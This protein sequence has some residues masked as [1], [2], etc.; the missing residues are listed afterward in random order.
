MR[1]AAQF[2]Q[3]IT[4]VNLNRLP[5]AIH[6]LELTLAREPNEPE[7]YHALGL[8]HLHN[9]APAEAKV[10]LARALEL[11]PH[12]PP[13]YRLELARACFECGNPES[14]N[15]QMQ[16]VLGPDHPLGYSYGDLLPYYVRTWES[17]ERLRALGYF[18]QLAAR[19]PENIS[20]LNNLAWI[21]SVSEFSPAH[22]EEALELALK[23]ARLG[24][25]DNPVL[26]DTLAA[27]YANAGRYQDAVESAEKARRAAQA[28][29]PASLIRRL[30]K[31]LGQYRQGKPWRES[32][33]R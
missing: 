31:R 30:D 25:G 16:I 14:A 24:S 18:R 1:V 28:Q 32:S 4:L 17:G 15:A 3:A 8:A 10:F 29:G 9:N 19:D 5:E 12:S 22:P 6:F 7:L 27:A 33:L 21:M 20:V 26:L 13:R 2:A 11:N 23:A